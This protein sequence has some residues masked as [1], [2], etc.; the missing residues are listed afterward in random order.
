[1]GRIVTSRFVLRKRVRHGR[2]VP[3]RA[4][5]VG[6]LLGHDQLHSV[7][8]A[9]HGVLWKGRG[10]ECGLRDII[11]G[12]KLP[13]GWEGVSLARERERKYDIMKMRSAMLVHTFLETKTST[14]KEVEVNANTATE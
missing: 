9:V 14:L 7:L 2:A 8:H 1:M 12:D 3:S 5:W 4:L 13:R 11:T 6:V 10:F